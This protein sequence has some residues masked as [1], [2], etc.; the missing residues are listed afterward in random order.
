MVSSQYVVRPAIPGLRDRSVLCFC[1]LKA[2]RFIDTEHWLK[3]YHFYPFFA[4]DS[5]FAARKSERSGI[6]VL[7]ERAFLQPLFQHLP[8][9]LHI[10]GLGQMPVHPGRLRLLTII[11]KS[12]RRHGDN[13]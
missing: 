11:R 13:R 9:L 7:S 5:A 3:S 1:L 4:S 12:I 2:S 10:E 6:G 8:Q